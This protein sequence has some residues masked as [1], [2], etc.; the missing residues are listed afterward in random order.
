MKKV[1]IVQGTIPH[2]RKP[3]FNLLCHH[4]MVTVLHSGLPS[5]S[6][7]D[8]FEEKINAVSKIGKFR[9]QRG[10]MKELNSGR[11]SA[12]ILMFD[13][14][15]LANLVAILFKKKVP[16]IYWGHKYGNNS[17]INFLRDK[18]MK[19]SDGIVLYTSE[20]IE[21]MVSRGIPK[22]K[23]F[24]AHNTVEVKNHSDNSHCSKDSF[25]YVGRAQERKQLDVLL[26][27]FSEIV[28]LIPPEVKINI[29]GSGSEN[30]VLKKLA[31]DLG[32]SHRVAF[33]NEVLD[34]Q[35]LKSL[36]QKAYAYVSPGHVGLGVL[37]SFS[38]GIPVVTSSNRIHA[39][40]YY[41][42]IDKKNCLLF[43]SVDE[44]KKHLILLCTDN[45]TSQKLGQEGYKLYIKQGQIENMVGGFVDAINFVTK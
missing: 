6:V 18:F 24:V 29:V 10:V 30:I 42:L 9:L 23:I 7:G 2:Y 40:E 34:E 27:A 44:L 39:Q 36:F 19:L 45:K 38:Y 41:N 31:E 15:W 37:H 14:W 16:V 26:I 11:Y 33:H 28:H 8:E 25:I 3:V 13:L 21:R 35:A 32:I 22:N 43:Q 1:L 5:V 17:L 12:V 20:D 4:Y